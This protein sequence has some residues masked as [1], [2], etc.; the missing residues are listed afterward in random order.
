MTSAKSNSWQDDHIGA[1]LHST[2]LQH[3]VPGGAKKFRF[4]RRVDGFPAH[5]FSQPMRRNDALF[6]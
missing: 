1:W 3:R 6:S 4:Y 5:A 2:A